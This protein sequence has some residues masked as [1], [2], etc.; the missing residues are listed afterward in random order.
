MDYVIV[1]NGVS[2]SCHRGDCQ[3]DQTGSI[4]I[5]S[6]EAVPTYGRPLI[7]YYLSDK[8]KFD[9]LPFRPEEFYERNQVTMRL[10]SRVLS[11]DAKQKVLILDC[12]D[13]VPYD[14]LLLATGGTPGQA[15][16]SALRDRACTTSP[17][18]PTPRPSRSWWTRSRTS[19]SSAPGSSRSRPPKGLPRRAWTGDHRSPLPDH[20]HL[21]RRDRGRAHC[22]PPGEERHPFHAGHGHQGDR[23]LRGRHHQGRGDRPGHG[24]GGRGHRGRGRA[25]EHGAGHPGRADHGAGHPRGRLHGDQ[26]RG[27]FCRG[28]RGRGQGPS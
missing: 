13:K 20:A 8:I 28:R 17:P 15:A 12:G 19:W 10:G 27:R 4:T 23:P 9:T 1:G 11:V 25:P 6:D 3:H 5:I 22:R 21:L 14:K 7:S 26:R 16:L 24:P 2:A 18:W